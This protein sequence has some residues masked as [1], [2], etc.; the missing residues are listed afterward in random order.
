MS[1]MADTTPVIAI[2]KNTGAKEKALNEMDLPFLANIP[3]FCEGNIT[4]II[5]P[6]IM[7]RVMAV[8]S[9]KRVQ[10]SLVFDGK[11]Q[12]KT[13]KHMRG[14]TECMRIPDSAGVN[15]PELIKKFNEQS[16]RQ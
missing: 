8:I 7:D 15:N 6:I 2:V 1:T 16:L 14:A 11:L 5:L 10:N 12:R 9:G 4:R 3:N 13:K